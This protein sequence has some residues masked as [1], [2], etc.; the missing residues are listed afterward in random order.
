MSIA[1]KRGDDGT[2]ALLFNKR[3]PKTHPR[4]ATYG[5]VDA[6]SA[7][8]GVCRA[9][10]ECPETKELLLSIQKQLV[11]LMGELATDDAD[12]ERFLEKKAEEAISSEMVEKFSQLIVEKE[13]QIRF[14][15]WVYS[16]STVAEAFLDQARTTC[17][18]AERAVVALKESGALVRPELI[19][20]L[21]RLADVLWLLSRE[22]AS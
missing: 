7:A 15:G 6:L 20:Y 8:L 1:T 11:Q 3:V 16:G 4:V 5:Q 19:H 17:R 9:H 13:G 22:Q 14:T 2:T 10:V 18:T 12:Q 21:N